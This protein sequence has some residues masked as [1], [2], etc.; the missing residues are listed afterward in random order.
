MLHR[1]RRGSYPERE[2]HPSVRYVVTILGL[3]SI[4]LAEFKSK[5]HD[6]FWLARSADPS[7]EGQDLTV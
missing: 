4:V 2:M 1:S 3:G 6:T 7:L 5:V